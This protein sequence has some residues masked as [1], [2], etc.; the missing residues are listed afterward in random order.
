M[1]LGALLPGSLLRDLVSET[2]TARI[3]RYEN[4]EI[5]LSLTRPARQ[6]RIGRAIRTYRGIVLSIARVHVGVVIEI[7]DVQIKARRDREFTI[8]P[9]LK[10]SLK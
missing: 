2:L 9:I 8:E 6:N 3:S 1:L 4:D 7:A 5:F 10:S